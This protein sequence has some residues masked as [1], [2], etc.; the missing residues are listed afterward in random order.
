VGAV[1]CR[2]GSDSSSSSTATSTAQETTGA[3]PASPQAKPQ[4]QAT[5]QGQGSAQAK[6]KPQ[7][8]QPQAPGDTSIQTFGAKA[9]GTEEQE[10]GEAMHSFFA[11]MA[12]G[13]YAKVCAGLTAANREQIEQYLKLKHKPGNCATVLAA[14]LSA[15]A[16][17]A[18]AAAAGT[19]NAVR[20]KGD[21]ALVLF[22]PK[23]GVKSYF[24]MVREGGG[25]KAV[26][27]STGTAL[28]PQAPG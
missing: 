25:W 28:S 24:A 22:T 17:E 20:I 5:K 26:S 12:T 16:P 27:L 1:G 23:G 2:G 13:D 8:A 19:L 11:A 6:P 21:Q 9:E 18:K 15:G 7:S 10:V 4:A 14:S 3:T